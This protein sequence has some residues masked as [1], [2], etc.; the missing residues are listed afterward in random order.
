MSVRDELFCY[1]IMRLGTGEWSM[2]SGIYMN[3]CIPDHM[4][5]QWQYHDVACYD[6]AMSVYLHHGYY[7]AMWLYLHHSNVML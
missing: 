3:Y 2:H 1:S 5:W 4:T 6:V 7:V